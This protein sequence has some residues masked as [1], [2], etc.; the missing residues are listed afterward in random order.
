MADG[1]LDNGVVVKRRSLKT[2]SNQAADAII[3]GWQLRGAVEEIVAAKT[4]GTPIL[5]AIDRFLMYEADLKQVDST[6]VNL[7]RTLLLKPSPLALAKRPG[8][9]RMLSFE[10]LCEKRGIRH[11]EDIG[12]DDLLAL[13]QAWRDDGFAPTT[14]FEKIKKM[15]AVL[16]FLKRQQIGSLDLRD[17]KNKRM[18]LTERHENPKYRPFEDDEMRCVLNVPM[19]PVEWAFILF[20][21]YTAFRLFDAI[22]CPIDALNGNQIFTDMDKVSDGRDPWISCALPDVVVD[23]LQQFEPMRKRFW[24]WDGRSRD[25]AN[26]YWHYRLKKIFTKA[27]VPWAHAHTLRNTFAVAQIVE[28]GDLLA[29]SKMLGHKSTQ[30]TENYYLYWVKKRETKLLMQQRTVHENDPLLKELAR[31]S[32]KTGTNRVHQMPSR[33]RS[34]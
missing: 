19:Q 11:I 23:A 27:G 4:A 22:S 31:A 10:E 9:R 3:R 8:M 24:F 20:L 5:K 2:T 25:C 28:H 32:S 16:D 13:R 7:H 18:S 30:T 34:A 21:R 33:K 1:R 12:L 17:L 14:I 6:T 26:Q 29:L 15:K